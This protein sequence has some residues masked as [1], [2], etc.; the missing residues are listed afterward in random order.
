MKKPKLIKRLLTLFVA[1]P[2]LLALT[3]CMRL[4]T[5]IVINEDKTGSI[6]MDYGMDKAMAEEMA[7]EPV[8]AED[9]CADMDLDSSGGTITPYDDGTYVGC[10]IETPNS[11][12]AEDSG[13]TW[14]GDEVHFQMDSDEAG[15]DDAGGEELDSSYFTD[16]EISVTFPGEVLTHNGSSTVNGTTVTW[17]NPSDLYS[18]EGLRATAKASGGNW[19]GGSDPGDN[20][21]DGR[22]DYIPPSDDDPGDDDPGDE[23]AKKD[24]SDKKDEDSGLPLWAWIAIGGG[25]VVVVGVVVALVLGG[26]KKKA[27][28]ATQAQQFAQGQQY[29]QPQYGQQQFGQPDQQHGQQ[30]YDQQQYGQ[31]YGQQQFGQQ[32]Q[33]YGQQYGQQQFDQGQQYGQQP[34]QGQNSGGYNNPPNPPY[35]G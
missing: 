8:T 4:K 10:L 21:Q 16:F 13:I 25:A 22:G 35:S 19:P 6:V 29:G 17:S 15:V 12:L 14:V 26:R 33:Q 3:S 7:G 31:Q 32:D 20:G 5:E 2:L 24:D 28:A 30:Q 27:K 1:L 23:P 18:A 11:P 9:F 34:D